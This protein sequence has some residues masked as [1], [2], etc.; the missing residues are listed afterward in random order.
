MSSG[1]APPWEDSNH[2]SQKGKKKTNCS[3]TKYI[4]RRSF[5]ATVQDC[6]ILNQVVESLLFTC[7]WN[8]CHQWLPDTELIQINAIFSFL[9]QDQRLFP[10]SKAN[11]G[12]ELSCNSRTPENDHIH[13]YSLSWRLC[14]ILNIDSTTILRIDSTVKRYHEF[15]IT[16]SIGLVKKSDV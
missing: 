13:I 8:K 9:S 3:A 10:C 12:L 16:A 6:R 4:W 14:T 11:R 7:S 1:R 2:Q 5:Q 15:L